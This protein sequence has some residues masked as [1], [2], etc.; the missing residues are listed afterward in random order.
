MAKYTELYPDMKP[1]EDERNCICRGNVKHPCC[2]C[3]DETEYFELNYEAHV[4][5]EECLKELDEQYDK[6]SRANHSEKSYWDWIP[7]Y[8][9]WQCRKC[10]WYIE[11]ELYNAHPADRGYL[12]CPH[13]G[14]E[15]TE[16]VAGT[17]YAGD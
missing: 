8:R 11:Q 9:Q 2:I 13:C 1:I 16:P 12:F 15:M 7:D 17:V 6:A 3:G 10:K 4:C 14:V 5:S